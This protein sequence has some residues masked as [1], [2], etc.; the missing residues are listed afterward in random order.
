MSEIKFQSS[1]WTALTACNICLLYYTKKKP[2]KL[3][4]A[5]ALQTHLDGQPHATAI[6]HLLAT[7]GGSHT[8][9]KAAAM[10]QRTHKGV[11]IALPANN[12]NFWKYALLQRTTQLSA[13]S[14][15]SSTSLTESTQ[16]ASTNAPLATTKSNK[17]QREALSSTSTS[18]TSSANTGSLLYMYV[19][20]Q[21]QIDG[22]AT[23]LA[24][25]QA[26]MDRVDSFLSDRSNPSTS[27]SIETELH[28]PSPTLLTSPPH[29]VDEDEDYLH[30]GLDEHELHEQS[31]HD[32]SNTTPHRSK[33][34]P[35]TT[36]N[37]RRRTSS[38]QGVAPPSKNTR[39][40]SR[41]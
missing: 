18:T 29:P 12:N 31:D 40:H 2:Y 1:W 8:K 4:D 21:Q 37:K 35:A 10:N 22:M 7:H 15:F 13:P 9:L 20:Q 14:T 34:A 5:N 33:S 17:R 28:M 36:G 11:K 25:M 3:H 32:T 26:I 23:Q 41:R 38:R 30:S 39:A 19:K 27:S 24:A 16:P 6:K